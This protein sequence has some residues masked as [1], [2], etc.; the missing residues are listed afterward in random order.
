MEWKV[1]LRYLKQYGSVAVQLNQ[2]NPV[3]EKIYEFHTISAICG[4][5][6]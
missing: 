4:Y 3:R 2:T 6:D 1:L 5:R